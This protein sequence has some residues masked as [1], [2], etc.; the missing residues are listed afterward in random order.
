MARRY[1]IKTRDI[2]LLPIGGIASLERMPEKPSQELAV[3]IVGPLINL[4]LAGLLWIGI[5]ATGGSTRITEGMSLG[6]ALATQLMWINIGLAVFN[7]VPAFPMDGGRVL[8]SI[9]AMR[10]H[11]PF[12]LDAIG[13]DLLKRLAHRRRGRS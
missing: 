6:G 1:G 13:D 4:A 9:L 12:L 3:A 2:M 8:R 7:L 10:M 11:A 5:T